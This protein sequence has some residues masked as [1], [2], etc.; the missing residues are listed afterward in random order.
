MSLVL[1]YGILSLAEAVAGFSRKGIR[2][3]DTYVLGRKTP[4]AGFEDCCRLHVVLSQLTLMAMLCSML[5]GNRCH[6]VSST[7]YG[8]VSQ[9][10]IIS[11]IVSVIML[12]VLVGF[13]AS[14]V[15]GAVRG[16]I[17][18]LLSKSNHWSGYIIIE[19][20]EHGTGV[21]VKTSYSTMV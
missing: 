14:F 15:S 18:R 16:T 13:V 4:L 12:A 11:I 21:R 19:P 9:Y 5:F 20:D 3:I 17:D 10:A 1:I 7:M 6:V 2:M 8:D